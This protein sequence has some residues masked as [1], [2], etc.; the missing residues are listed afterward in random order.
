MLPP[1]SCCKANFDGASKGNLGPSGC[2]GIIR[3][4]Y[5]EGIMA[6]S[7]PLGTQS[8]HFAEAKDAYEAIKLAFDM[9]FRW[10]WL[11]GDS[12]NIIDCIKCIIQP[13]WTIS[14][15]IEGTHAIMDKFERV[16]VTHV[17][18][19][20]NFMAD[21]FANDGVRRNELMIWKMGR[22]LLEEANN[23]INQEKISRSMIE[24]KK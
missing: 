7:L 6:F 10:L 18:R 8:N 14:N 12:K 5:G 23:I 24:I 19:E 9:G 2:N 13:S 15:I 4:S 17:Y 3:N 16:Y 20:A 21:W 22:K 1:E 11:E